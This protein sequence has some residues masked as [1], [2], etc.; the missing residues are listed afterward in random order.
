VAV[1]R[2]RKRYRE[3]FRLEIA[4]TVA[5]PADVD[6]E[7]R[8]LVAALTRKWQLA[9]SRRSTRRSRIAKLALCQNVS[10]AP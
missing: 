3:L 2:L 6:S 7:L 1:H 4:E 10:D 8:V 9:F 5:D